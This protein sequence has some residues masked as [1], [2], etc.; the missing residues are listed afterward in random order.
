ME[1]RDLEDFLA[2]LAH[3]SIL[4][5]AEERGLAQPALSRRIRA[6]ER[7]LGVQLLNRS[8][9]GVSA[10]AQGTLLERHA[11]LLLRQRAR[12]LEEL[13]AQDDGAVGHARVGVAPV[14]SGLVPLAIERLCGERP[15]LSFSV[16]EGV[17]D[18]LVRDLRAAE[19]DG[20]FSLIPPDTSLDGLTVQTL[21]TERLRIVCHPRN[22][23]RRRKRLRLSELRDA[24]WALMRQPRSMVDAFLEIARARG[25]RSPRI[26]VRTDSL[27]VL[28]TLV[29]RGSFLTALP[30]GAVRSELEEKRG[31][32]LQ[33]VERLP[34][35]SAAWIQRQEALPRGLELLRSEVEAS[36]TGA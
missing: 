6:L 33:T 31:A 9:R 19:I 13:H 36:I 4:G 28:K 5:A 15:G 1:L 26:S 14:L 10:T 11:T 35:A 21:S 3:G 32:V 24:K 2:V 34:A 25:L 17:F 16:H 7:S 30:L 27:D 18:S 22:P 20:V 12:A 29:F 8:S 23:L